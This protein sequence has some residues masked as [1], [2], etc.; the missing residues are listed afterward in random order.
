MASE[1]ILILRKDN[2]LSTY[3]NHQ[4]KIT[5]HWLILGIGTACNIAGF[6]IV[7][8]NKNRNN[9][10]HFTTLHGKFGLATVVLS[11][12][13]LCGGSFALY[14][15]S[16]KSYI[17][18]KLNKALHILAGIL[19]YALAT[20]TFGFSLYSHWFDSRVHESDG[21]KIIFVV[22]VAVAAA[23]TVLKPCTSLIQKLKT[24]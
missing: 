11:I 10:D 17:K 23:W 12:L 4:W 14:S 5:L 8:I 7:V 20:V 15:A 19:S 6:V 9:R 16:L 1:G 21:V 24:S 2:I 22:V 13:T 18:P 3:I